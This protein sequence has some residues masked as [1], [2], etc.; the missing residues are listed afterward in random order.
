MARK[1]DNGLERSRSKLRIMVLS[2]D[3]GVERVT[4]IELAL[5]AWEADVLPL[6]YTRTQAT[7]TPNGA[8]SCL[9]LARI[10]YR[11]AAACISLTSGTRAAGHNSP[12][13]VSRHSRCSGRGV[14]HRR[15]DIPVGRSPER[16]G[17]ILRP[18]GRY[19]PVRV[20]HRH[21]SCL[22]ADDQ[23]AVHGHGAG[24]AS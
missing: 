6:N 12:V 10:S 2:W 22:I 14:E 16:P 4:R 15:Y 1:I 8:R 18:C 3:Y 21:A 5:S 7:L 19:R 17:H 11:T 13:P 23:T 24:R 9:L 20:I